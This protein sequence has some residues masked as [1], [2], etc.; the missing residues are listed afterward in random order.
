M[1]GREVVGV[2]VCPGELSQHPTYPQVAHHRS[3][4]QVRCRAAHAAHTA[5]GTGPGPAG[6]SR[7]AQWRGTV[8]PPSGASRQSGG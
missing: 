7:W 2:G 6:A 8:R 3:R 4:R 5:P 1:P